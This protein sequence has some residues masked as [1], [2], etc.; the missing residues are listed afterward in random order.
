VIEAEGTMEK[1][2]VGTGPF[3]LVKYEPASVIELKKNENFFRKGLPYLDAITRPIIPDR[4]A[5]VA[6]L[7]SGQVMLGL[8]WPSFLP[9]EIELIKK[10]MGDRVRVI[11]SYQ[12]ASQKMQLQPGFPPL[13]DARVRRAI[14]L[15]VDRW[16]IS[17]RVFE[18]TGELGGILDSRV[19]GDW[20]L[21]AEEVQ[22]L[23]GLRKDKTEDLAEAKRLLADAGYPNGLE[24]TWKVRNT[25]DYISTATVVAAQLEKIGI[26]STIKSLD[27]SAGI[28]E[29]QGGDW[30]LGA[31]GGNA[32][33][34]HALGVLAEYAL[35]TN[36]ARNEQP[37]QPKA[38]T[39]LLNQAMN[40]TDAA[41]AKQ[42]VYELQRYL[43]TRDAPYFPVNWI[44]SPVV[45]SSKLHGYAAP[46]WGMEEG[47]DHTVEWLEA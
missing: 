17:Q 7:A 47:H 3:K 24:L 40:T 27:P 8:Q 6:A 11:N 23:P 34:Q 15:A 35:P 25:A 26:K 18:G 9:S 10:Q 33:G 31:T 21:P 20:A 4:A 45:V 32:F 43:L 13:N 1:T 2:W 12:N 30:Q 14:F 37:W 22:K 29:L 5:E 42:L 36:Y 38:Y 41:R 44:D 39:D 16:E 46:K 28:A 19:Y